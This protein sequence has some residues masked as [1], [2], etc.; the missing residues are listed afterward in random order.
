MPPS[1]SRFAS[2]T[3]SN[4]ASSTKSASSWPSSETYG[5]PSPTRRMPSARS[6]SSRPPLVVTDGAPPPAEDI[7]ERSA[8]S[9]AN[10]FT[11]LPEVQA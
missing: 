2:D 10:P 11:K 9:P 6:A 1:I 5:V 3:A 7:A 8:A 4:P